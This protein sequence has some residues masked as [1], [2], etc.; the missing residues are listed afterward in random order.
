MK[1]RTNASFA[2]SV[3]FKPMRLGQASPRGL[4]DSRARWSRCE[5]RVDPRRRCEHRSLGRCRRTLHPPD[6]RHLRFGGPDRSVLDGKGW[7]QASA[8]DG[9]LQLVFGIG[10]TPTGTC[11]MRVRGCRGASNSGRYE[12]VGAGRKTAKRSKWARCATRSMSRC[13]ESRCRWHPTTSSPSV[14]NG[15]SRAWF[16]RS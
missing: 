10:G 14:S 3:A 2:F 15:N 9:S 16:P 5:T 8:N 4:A 12:R 7:V 1:A 11:S 6:R 13:G